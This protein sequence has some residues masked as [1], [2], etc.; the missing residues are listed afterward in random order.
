M[1]LDEDYASLFMIDQSTLRLPRQINIVGQLN[2]FSSGLRNGQPVTEA[3][4]SSLRALL[5]QETQLRQELQ[6]SL[7]LLRRNEPVL[8]KS[9]R[10]SWP[11]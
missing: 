10:L 9:S 6:Q 3:D 7:K 1:V 2:G 8:T 5:K 4:R 11:P